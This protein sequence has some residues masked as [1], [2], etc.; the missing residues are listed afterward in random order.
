MVGYI[1][2]EMQHQYIINLFIKCSVI[3]GVCVDYFRLERENCCSNPI[4]VNFI[5]GIILMEIHIWYTNS[6]KSK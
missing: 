3:D 6:A 4:D 2:I 1:K 5:F